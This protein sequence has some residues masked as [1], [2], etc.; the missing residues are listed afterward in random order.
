MKFLYPEML[1]GL[2][3]V[4]IPIIIHL[5]SFR[6]SKRVYF[7]NLRFLREVK[8]E[9]TSKSRLKHLLVLLA[10]C[11]AIA[12]LVLA[13]AQPFFPKENQDLKLQSNRAI[14]IYLDNSFSMNALSKEG[15]LLDEAKN[16][17]RNLLKEFKPSDKFQLL[18]NDFEGKHQRLVSQNEFLNLLEDV[19]ISP[20][21]KKISSIL[22]RQKEALNKNANYKLRYLISDFQKSIS[23]FNQIQAD[24][25]IQT[26]LVKVNSAQKNNVFIDTCW[27]AVPV[28]QVGQQSQLIFRISN[29]GEAEAEN[30][31][32]SLKVDGV[33]K[34]LSN[35]DIEANTFITDTISFNITKTGWNK[36]ILELSDHPITF[37]DK[38]FLTFR[39]LPEIPVLVI[40][41][42]KQ[43]PF[44]KAFF[45]N[46]TYLKPDFALA[47]QL[48][49]KKLASYKTIILSNLNVIDAGL[50]QELSKLIL[51]GTSVVLFPGTKAKASDLNNFLSSAVGVNFGAL[52]K[53][54]TSVRRLNLEDP[55]FQEVFESVPEN[56]DLPKI[57]QYYPLISSSNSQQINLMQLSSNEPLLS[58]F[59][60]DNGFL[61]V[62][63][64]PL[65]A[66]FSNL[67]KH[68]L[69]VPV[70]YRIALL[71][72]GNLPLS[73]TLG[74]ANLIPLPNKN[75]SNEQ[76][77]EFKSK[78]AA[79][80]PE[81]IRNANQTLIGIN[82][83]VENANF[84]ELKDK[85]NPDSSAMVLA[86]NFNRKE[87]KLDFMEKEKLKEQAEQKGFQSYDLKQSDQIKAML[88]A[89]TQSNWWRIFLFLA[90][91]FFGLETLFLRIFK[92][93]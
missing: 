75:I 12:C 45:A 21:V 6:R 13:F 71:S 37:D 66:D 47:K 72:A 16:T 82:N 23:D 38:Y 83:E 87:S 65:D 51:A 39:V 70:L 60:V 53:Q 85:S 44:I 8:E 36:A 77:F 56:L 48:D 73:Y 43:N 19:Q 42:Q 29:Q 10:R 32:V 93:S 5:F 14:S 20:S 50:S 1:W 59:S 68:A 89:E 74:Q 88:N 2:L 67:P 80:I 49:Y 55:T 92:T 3:F 58:K 86:L 62:S 78:D 24:S 64:V 22:N 7:S 17:A 28:Q 76:V 11:L 26:Y 41:E 33:Q 52:K 34:G 4:A 27:F 54:E 63:S 9:T 79:F 57:Q 46:E 69:F 31:R 15:T 84:Y 35:L 30:V 25:S 90:L 91:L 81:L 40:E 61:Y 18:T